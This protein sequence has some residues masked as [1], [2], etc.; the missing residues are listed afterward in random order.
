MN[1]L[2]ENSLPIYDVTL[3]TYI[4][5]FLIG[6]LNLSKLFLRQVS[7]LFRCLDMATLMKVANRAFV[8]CQMFNSGMIQ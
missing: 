8:A 6:L 3:V 1:Q 7:G 5:Y 4:C 2:P